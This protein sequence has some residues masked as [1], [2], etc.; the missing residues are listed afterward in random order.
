MAGMARGPHLSQKLSSVP[1]N[2]T[3]GHTPGQTPIQKDTCAAVFIAALLTI[4][5]TWIQPKC[6]LTDECMKKVWSTGEMQ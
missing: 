1:S 5:K 6:P 2:P 3:A 4:A